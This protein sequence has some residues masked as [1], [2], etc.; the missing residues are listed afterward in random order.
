MGRGDPFLKIL[1][2][3]LFSIDKGNLQL[4]T[5]LSHVSAVTVGPGDQLLVADNQGN[6]LVST[7]GRSWAQPSVPSTST[8]DSPPLVARPLLTCSQGRLWLGKPLSS[9]LLLGPPAPR[10]H[11]W[12]TLPLSLTQ[13]RLCR[14]WAGEREAYSGRLFLATTNPT[15]LLWTKI[16]GSK[17]RPLQLPPG[18]EILH[19]AALPS[20]LWLLTRRGGIFIRS[21]DTWSPLHLVQLGGR[22]LVSLSIGEDQ[23]WAADSEGGVWLRLGSLLPPPLHAAPAWLPVDNGA[24]GDVVQ[25][26]SSPSGDHVWARDAGGGLWAREAV[27]PELPCGAGWVEV[28]G[29]QAAWIEISKKSGDCI[30]K[31]KFPISQL[32]FL[33]SLDSGHFWLALPADRTQSNGLDRKVLGA[34]AR[35]TWRFLEGDR[36]W[37]VRHALGSCL[38]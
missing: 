16:H 25:V 17:V 24:I 7:S 30:T 35:T 28:P 12:A 21:N 37:A 33:R 1:I 6:L 15:S 9:Q 20:A 2:S 11:S 32:I 13:G 36:G 4:E 22:R 26:A 10:C 38:C 27:Y 5:G 29:V 3:I 23:V 31:S 14:L 34:C 18:E 19:L 8:S